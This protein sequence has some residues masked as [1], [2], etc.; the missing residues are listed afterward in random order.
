MEGE[1]EGCEVR[2][3]REQ[4]RRSNS[5]EDAMAEEEEEDIAIAFLP[6]LCDPIV[7]VS[8][9]PCSGSK[10]AEDGERKGDLSPK[11]PHR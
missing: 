6:A 5:R 7:H 3:R 9:K 4:Q 8:L 1:R 11:H 2:L 10:Q